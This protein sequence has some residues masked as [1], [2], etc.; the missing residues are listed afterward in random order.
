MLLPFTLVI[1]LSTTVWLRLASRL[2]KKRSVIGGFLLL[3]TITSL[4][5]P[6]FPAGQLGPPMTAAVA[7]GLLVGVIFLLDATVA[8]FVDYDE[9]K[10]GQHREGL[11]FGVW[12]MA[13]KLARALG[14]AA[15][16]FLLD[17]IGFLPGQAS[18][19]PGVQYGLGLVFGPGVG[20]FFVAAA[21]VYLF[22]P[23]DEAVHRRVRGLLER[24]EALR[25]RLRGLRAARPLPAAGALGS[26]TQGPRV[27]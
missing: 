13:A 2:G 22:M 15:S 3:G 26:T 8:D 21:L 17:A 24:R 7:A 4:A 25:A 14:L 5:Y 16:G 10:T 19:S 9:L 20:L 1:A 6:F 23:L 11:Y 27:P 18:Q 12:R